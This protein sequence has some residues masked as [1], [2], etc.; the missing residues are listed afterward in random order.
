MAWGLTGSSPLTLAAAAAGAFGFFARA[1]TLGSLSGVTYV[2]PFLSEMHGG[3]IPQ[4][5]GEHASVHTALVVAGF[6]GF[7][8]VVARLLASRGLQIPSSIA[9]MIFSFVVM[10]GAER[11]CGRQFA[12]QLSALVRPGVRF[13][14]RYMMSF[15]TV[16]VVPIPSAIGELWGQGGALTLAKVLLVHCAG[17]CF[18]H[19]STAGVA[20]ALGGSGL[21]EEAAALPAPPRREGVSAPRLTARGEPISVDDGLHN[22]EQQEQFRTP[23]AEEMSMGKRLVSRR[24]SVTGYGPGTVVGFNKTYLQG[25]STH[26]IEFDANGQKVTLKLAR[27]SNTDPEKKQW[28]IAPVQA[29]RVQVGTN[30]DQVRNVAPAARAGVFAAKR[31]RDVQLTIQ[32]HREAI[33]SAW[34]SATCLAYAALPWVGPAPALIGTLQSSLLH[35]ERLKW[36]P[37]SPLIISAATTSL[38]CMCMGKFRGD[39]IA[40][41]FAKYYKQGGSFLAGA[42]NFHYEL[43]SAATLALG[44]RMF[45][46]RRIVFSRAFAIVGSVLFASTTSLF[47]TPI[48]AKAVG[49]APSLALM[50]SQRCALQPLELHL[51]GSNHIVSEIPPVSNN[52][53]CLAC[54]SVTT[55]FALA[56]ATALGASTVLTASVLSVGALHCALWG[57]RLLQSIAPGP[58]ATTKG[59]VPSERNKNALA[60]GLAF[61]C[62]SYGTG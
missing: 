4:A 22:I 45:E 28:L 29:R 30:D 40:V 26:D 5:E 38:A 33:R 27:K 61:G 21:V 44:F 3:S 51:T 16:V 31:A 36:G 43:V 1:P 20:R 48:V 13:L 35:A 23:T 34:T 24:I 32:L 60:R 17:W 47:L 19:V 9:A 37:A 53:E 59:P 57:T 39:T 46:M 55:P 14:G 8:K 56:G 25:A 18:T 10:V 62:S 41:S 42:G 2:R 11:I 6:W 52:T 58:S 50:L 12:D 15:L 54:S 7:D 49:L